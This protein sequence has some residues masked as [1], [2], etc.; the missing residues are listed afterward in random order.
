MKKILL[1]GGSGFI[2]RNILESH[3][4]EKHEIQAPKSFELNLLDSLS[5]DEYFKGKE[6]DVVLHSAR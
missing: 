4:S 2:G 5:V 1:T 3:L 6:F